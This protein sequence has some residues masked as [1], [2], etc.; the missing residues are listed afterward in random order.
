MNLS[1]IISE[2]NHTLVTETCR[3]LQHGINLEVEKIARDLRAV[4][5]EEGELTEA[6]QFPALA[7][8]L[9]EKVNTAS[10][11]LDRAKRILSEVRMM[12]E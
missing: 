11:V 10:G 8:A 3:E 6:R 1:R 4:V 5:A 7:R 2:A 12:E 9:R